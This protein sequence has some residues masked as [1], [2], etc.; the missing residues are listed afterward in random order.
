MSKS[1][2][3]K[4]YAQGVMILTLA[5]LFVKVLSMVYRIPFQNLVGDEGFYI[6]Q[7]VYPFV[8]VFVTWT[9]SGLAIAI[10]RV[11]TESNEPWDELMRVILRYLCMLA[12]VLFIGLYSL[13]S[14]FASIM[15]DMGLVPLLKAGSYIALTIPF[16]ALYKGHAQAV[17][18]LNIVAKSQ[19]AEQVVRVAIIL[20]GT[21]FV[22]RLGASLYVA[23]EVATIGTVLGEV[24]GVLLLYILMRKKGVRL[25]LKR[26]TIP[27]A[28]Q[29]HLMKRLAIYSIGISLSSLLLILFQLVDS[30][31]IFRALVDSGMSVGEA[32]IE[33]GIY[34]RGQPL[35]QVG[36]VLASSLTMAIVP[37]IT[38]AMKQHDKEDAAHYM[39]LTYSISILVGVA[40]AVGLILVM[41]YMNEMMFKTDALSG[42]LRLFVLQIVWL[43]IIMPM[44]AVLQGLGYTKHP[45]LLLI[46]G[47]IVK[48]LCNDVFIQWFGIAGAALASN[49]GLGFTALLLI[50]FLKKVY[51]ISLVS[52]TFTCGALLATL[53]MTFAVEIWIVGI[54]FMCATYAIPPRITATITA[55]TA[56][57]VGAFAFL[58][59][60]AKREVLSIEDWSVLPLGRRVAAFQLY[61]NR[62]KK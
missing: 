4:E 35:V 6:Y 30:L 2:G 55:L 27:R 62:V 37:F 50:R 61:V 9:A 13:S 15:G 44:M 24:V 47:L 56:V 57:F 21:W 45:S 31:T 12:L 5:M 19:V 54:T 20:M 16:L 23:G 51:P 46:G 59:V 36:L 48:L 40:A 43:S 10:S 53:A 11:L 17:G 49:V 42:V 1:S 39:R 18:D 52:P 7:Q 28:R 14:F 38:T 8:A 34:D 33:K 60:S 32:M 41:P 22:M 25:S 29:H 58:T 3:M 26:S